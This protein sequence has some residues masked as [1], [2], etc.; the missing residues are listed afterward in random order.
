[1]FNWG[2]AIAR[3]A[4]FDLLLPIF[5]NSAF[6]NGA[7]NEPAQI[8]HLELPCRTPALQFKGALL[9]DPARILIFRSPIDPG[10]QKIEMPLRMNRDRPP[11]LLVTMNRF[12][13][14]SKQLRHLL[15]SFI[16][17]LS[18][19]REFLAI[20]YLPRTNIQKC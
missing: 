5:M 16:Q 15:L 19:G 8:S 7:V 1:V 14:T 11:S 10:E 3:F 13:R 6:T 12:K 20:H 17:P 9:L 4:D 18:D 2:K